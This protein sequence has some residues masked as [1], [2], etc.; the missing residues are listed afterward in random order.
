M[1]ITK[2]LGIALILCA[3]Y[4]LAEKR[5]LRTTILNNSNQ[6][7]CI[8]IK[9][10]RLG[11]VVEPIGEI[12]PAVGSKTYDVPFNKDHGQQFLIISTLHPTP[13][14]PATV[15]LWEEDAHFIASAGVK[16]ASASLRLQ[17]KQPII[18]LTVLIN[19]PR[20]VDIVNLRNVND[21][22]NQ[23]FKYA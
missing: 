15:R 3:S 13:Y 6:V 4:A 10:I 20:S 5:I 22:H 23:L 14:P 19:D 16:P 11:E 8:G 21:I 2:L 18:I 9:G 12:E 7:L 1:N 17:G